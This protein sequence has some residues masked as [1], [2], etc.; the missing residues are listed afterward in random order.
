MHGTGRVNAYSCYLFY[1]NDRYD[2]KVLKSSWE[3]HWNI[4]AAIA[5]NA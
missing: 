2:N 5:E 4:F 3:R 1:D